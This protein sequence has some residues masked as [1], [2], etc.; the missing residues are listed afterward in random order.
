MSDTFPHLAKL[1]CYIFIAFFF[2]TK[3]SLAQQYP[4]QVQANINS[5]ASLKLSEYYTGA[6]PTFTI[7]LTN[8]DLNR[9]AK[10]YL[11]FRILGPNGFSLQTN[12]NI[13]NSTNGIDLQRGIPTKLSSQDLQVYFN[14][15][16]LQEINNNGIS[17]FNKGGTL[18]AGNYIFRIEVYNYADNA[19]LNNP[20]Q[21]TIYRFLDKPQ[22]PILNMPFNQSEVLYRDANFITFSWTPQHT[23]SIFGSNTKYL[24]ELVEVVDRGVDINTAFQSSRPVFSKELFSLT[25]IYGPSQPLLLPGKRYAWRVQVKVGDFEQDYTSFQNNGYSPIYYFD[26]NYDCPQPDPRFI[27]IPSDGMVE[28]SWQGIKGLEYNVSW[29]DKNG[30]FKDAKSVFATADGLLK[31]EKKYLYINE[32][33]A[34]PKSAL[35]V[36]V[37]CPDNTI[38]QPISIPYWDIPWLRDSNTCNPSYLTSTTIT[39]DFVSDEFKR[40]KLE[41]EAGSESN[42]YFVVFKQENSPYS[43]TY[44]PFFKGNSY[45]AVLPLNSTYTVSVGF[46]C[47]ATNQLVISEGQIISIGEDETKYCPKPEIERLTLLNPGNAILVEW[48]ENQY[49]AKYEVKCVKTSDPNQVIEPKIY[50]K[51]TA[52]FNGLDFETDY[53][54]IVVAK[55]ELGATSSSSLYTKQTSVKTSIASEIVKSKA[56]RF[57]GSIKGSFYNLKDGNTVAEIRTQQENST[58]ITQAE[59]G[60]KFFYGLKNCILNIYGLTNVND[61]RNAQLIETIYSDVNGNYSGIVLHNQKFV[62]YGIQPHRSSNY[63][64]DS[65]ILLDV[66]SLQ[67]DE[68]QNYVI[69]RNIELPLNQV[70]YHPSVHI[71]EMEIV[72]QDKT[73]VVV[74][75]LVEKVFWKKHYSALSEVLNLSSNP[76]IYNGKDYISIHTVKNSGRLVPLINGTYVYRVRP[77]DSEPSKISGIAKG[78]RFYAAENGSNYVSQ[79]LNYSLEY[80]LSGIVSLNK[81]M[82]PAKDA[83]IRVFINKGDIIGDHYLGFVPNSNKAEDDDNDSPKWLVKKVQTSSDGYYTVLLP[84]LKEGAIIEIVADYEGS[85]SATQQVSLDYALREYSTIFNFTDETHLYVGRAMWDNKPVNDALVQIGEK[86][87]R[88]SAD[89]YFLLG[90]TS[91]VNQH[92]VISKPGLQRTEFSV[93]RQIRIEASGNNVSENAKE[94]IDSLKALSHIET[95]LKERSIQLDEYSFYLE[96][97][98]LNSREASELLAHLVSPEVKVKEIKDIG[99]VSLNHSPQTLY[100]GVSSKS[101]LAN[102][103][104]SISWRTAGSDTYQSTQNII[105]NRGGVANVIG[106]QPGVYE[107]LISPR[108]NDF[109]P[110]NIEY[111]V[112][113]DERSGGNQFEIVLQKAVMVQLTVKGKSKKLDGALVTLDDG[114][115]YTSN[116]D[117]LVSFFIPESRADD[118]LNFT[119]SKDGFDS[120]T[121]RRTKNTFNEPVNLDEATDVISIT[122]LDGFDVVLYKQESISGRSGEYK[123]SGDLRLTGSGPIVLNSTKL[124]FENA[125]VKVVPTNGESGKAELQGVLNFTE[126]FLNGKLYSVYPVELEGVYLEKGMVSANK[127]KLKLDYG[128]DVNSETK[129]VFNAITEDI[130]L[131]SNT[132]TS[133]GELKVNYLGSSYSSNVQV[134]GGN[135]SIENE[136][137]KLYFENK[138]NRVDKLEV[139]MYGDL[140]LFIEAEKTNVTKS[141]INLPGYFESSVVNGLNSKIKTNTPNLVITNSNGTISTALDE[142]GIINTTTGVQKVKLEIEGIR[143]NGL[144]SNNCVAGLNG[145]I[146][147]SANQMAN[148]FSYASNSLK[149]TKLDFIRTENACGLQG[150]LRSLDGININGLTLLTSTTHPLYFAYLDS[151]N[152]FIIITSGSLGL[153]ESST[154]MAASVFF[155]NP[156]DVNRFELLTSTWSVFLT[157]KKNTQLNLGVFKVNVDA[158]ALHIAPK[159]ELATMSSLLLKPI[160]QI[161]STQSGREN[162]FSTNANNATEQLQIPLN[163]STL[164]DLSSTDWIVGVKGD[165]KFPMKNIAAKSNAMVAFGLNSG[166][167]RYAINELLLGIKHQAFTLETSAK[168]EIGEQVT[169]FE[170][171][172][173]IKVLENEMDATFKLL[174]YSDYVDPY[175]GSVISGMEL[176]A[177]LVSQLNREMTTGPISWSEMGGGLN[178]NTTNSIYEVWLYGKATNLGNVSSEMYVDVARL[179]VLFNTNLCGYK[180][181]LEGSGTL[182][183]N[184]KEWFDV[185]FKA[186]YCRSLLLFRMDGSIPT[187]L[188][189]PEVYGKGVMFAGAESSTNKADDYLFLALNN[190]MSYLDFFDSNI[191]FVFGN[192]VSKNRPELASEISLLWNSVGKIALDNT[193]NIFDG[194]YL[195]TK[196]KGGES[197]GT[198]NLG[199]VSGEYKFSS[200]ATGEFYNKTGSNALGLNVKLSALSFIKTNLVGISASGIANRTLELPGGYSDRSE[201]DNL[202]Y[203]QWNFAGNLITPLEI[204][205]G[206]S[207][208]CNE[209][210]FGNVS[211]CFSGKY[212]AFK[213]CTTLKA[214]VKYKEDSPL[215]VTISF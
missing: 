14:S 123:I 114:E 46:R 93:N 112:F 210:R 154:D 98:D 133:K 160:Q 148:G 64:L 95:I 164:V 1:S 203:N 41:W 24:F 81:E 82:L 131:V 200:N 44:T 192:N 103:S 185:G 175:T 147:L 10:V 55:C 178:C 28:V 16:A 87:T 38:K 134:E 150:Q 53:S 108:D 60:E 165:V 163:S 62:Q 197:N 77:M 189:L 54:F 13:R 158:I 86:S 5:P 71:P 126:T 115:V 187:L 118:Y 128:S 30:S 9:D 33:E 184:D 153:D 32:S 145:S 136:L 121:E 141:R 177:T 201:S 26:Y 105:L 207:I 170:A 194:T 79:T 193:G 27:V 214:S 137:F 174:N 130:W 88:T 120:K 83:S 17:I 19:L 42:E 181:V 94:V 99:E 172:A 12:E 56:I 144:G 212:T 3:S 15:T 59:A 138:G 97:R 152:S 50:E 205:S 124:S 6:N 139:E 127:V 180:P 37:V 40:V 76:V 202:Q 74:D 142:S 96:N 109:M 4:I 101:V 140:S 117:G 67:T 29:L 179:G 111:E 168:L 169:G 106:V 183:M 204:S 113:W 167:F 69:D 89:G 68:L 211:C 166:Q 173:K 8:R 122:S 48:F 132:N 125:S 157:P 135:S 195:S 191:D 11:K 80:K 90:L 190:K 7:F 100:I 129:S 52:L 45:Q 155:N 176:S 91:G 146:R 75:I 35:K 171:P 186:D 156:I 34:Y 23:G 110:I 73:N 107:F 215:N 161:R 36:E 43:V 213:A 199:I 25:L 58:A 116:Q 2:G 162:Y 102:A 49:Q 51:N 143:I 84:F 47:K 182:Y 188:E 196:L 206:G 149:A 61:I 57:K 70:Y 72:G 85:T 208:G 39:A 20:D 21:S 209:M 18:P 104:A 78:S 119:T 65:M 22:A 63:L 198:G 92:V 151:K 31:L 66:D 159:T